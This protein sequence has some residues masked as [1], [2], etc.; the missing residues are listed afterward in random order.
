VAVEL[1]TNQA[2]TTVASGGTSAPA[3][4]TQE[5]WTVASSASFPAAAT[6]TSAFHVADPA[7]TATAAEIVAVTN[8]SGTTWTVTRGAESSTPVAHTAGFTVQQVITA[9][10]L[11]VFA[12]AG[13]GDLGGTGAAPTVTGTHLSAALPLAQGGTGQT[14]QQAAMDALAGGTTLGRFLR[15]NGTHVQLSAIQPTDLPASSALRAVVITTA[16]ATFSPLVALA[17]GSSA[18]VTWT[19]PNVT[20]AT[21]LNPTLSFGSTGTRTVYMTVADAAG[22]DA[23]SQ[24][25][26]FNIGFNHADDSGRSSLSSSFDYTSQAVTGVSGISNMTGLINFCAANIN[27]ANAGADLTGTLDFT[28]LSQLQ[29]IECFN[30]RVTAAFVGGCTSLIRYCVE[31][32]SMT[33]LNINPMQPNLFD[34]RSAIQTSNSLAFTPLAIS[35]KQLWHYCVRDQI[36]TGFPDLSLLPVVE[37]LWTWNTRQSGTIAPVS[38]VVWSVEAASNDYT[39]ATMTNLFVSSKD[40][41]GNAITPDLDLAANSLATATLTGC[42]AL[43]NIQLQDNNLNQAA[44]DGVLTTVN[45]FSTS[46]GTLR[47]RGNAAPSGTGTAAAT[48]LTGRGWTVTTGAG[49][50]AVVQT[51]ARTSSGTLTFSGTPAAGNSIILVV[52]AFNN[53]G[54]MSASAPTLNGSPVTG[55]FAIFNPGAGNGVSSAAQGGNFV[56][57]TAW[58][59]PN[60]T[61][62]NGVAIS[63]AGGASVTGMIAYEVSG[64]G[65][66]PAASMSKNAAGTASLAVDQGYTAEASNAQQIIIGCS[67]IYG[68]TA[69]APAAPWTNLNASGSSSGSSPTWTGYRFQSEAIGKAYRY[70]QTASSNSGP[71][72]TGV[73]AVHA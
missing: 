40:G 72:C 13:N 62:A 27:V 17:A 21:G 32:N 22:Y 43:L 55:T 48:A 24:V 5:T 45:G 66:A 70:L 37:N 60:V 25:Q 33:A 19:C 54:G 31:E 39:T 63:L 11:S 23:I 41:A 56:F 26:T 71:W 47:L 42:T 58:V 52:G 29:H 30:S 67:Q 65:T 73:F 7:T 16:G 46:N 50:I 6:G 18:T 12:Q 59:L 9:A 3:S 57:L 34:F 44:V 4:G 10:S 69:A 35:A 49:S 51:A 14:A 1:F 20:T 15:G 61:A 8:V 53:A 36:V 68:Q 28:G 2:S 38:T 64:L